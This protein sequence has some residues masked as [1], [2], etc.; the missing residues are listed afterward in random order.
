MAI[1]R[2]RNSQH[3]EHNE[4]QADRPGEEDAPIS[5]V[6]GDAAPEVGLDHIA[7]DHSQHHRGGAKAVA[8]EEVAEDAEEVIS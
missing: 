6:H 2:Q 1:Q 5:V 3:R 7:Q 4:G 8:V